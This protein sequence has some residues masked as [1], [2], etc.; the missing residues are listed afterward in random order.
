MTATSYNYQLEDS[1]QNFY[2]FWSEG[3]KGRIQKVVVFHHVE[4]DLWN[5][6]FGDWN[7]GF[8]DYE[9]ITDNRDT[10]RIMATV[11]EIATDFM[12]KNPDRRLQIIPVDDRRKSLYNHAIRR[13]FDVFN[14]LFDIKGFSENTSENY[15][16]NKFYD[17][18]E[19][20]F[21]FK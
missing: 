11:A 12:S 1:N 15:K 14:I 17:S 20:K 8:I 4:A 3:V 9:I 18:F 10:F 2:F 7:G 19:L 16:P 13:H 5:L 6:G 21:R